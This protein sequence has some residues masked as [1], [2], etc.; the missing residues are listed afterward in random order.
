MP[1][2]ANTIEYDGLIEALRVVLVKR[3]RSDCP[4]CGA[5]RYRGN[6]RVYCT[7]CGVWWWCDAHRTDANEAAG[8]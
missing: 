4:V 7:V 5:H 6:R 8:E 1:R 3:Y 2:H